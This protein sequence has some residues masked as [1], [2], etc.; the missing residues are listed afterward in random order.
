[1]L[2]VAPN[3]ASLKVNGK[4]WK[5]VKGRVVLSLVWFKETIPC[6]KIYKDVAQDDDYRH[7]SYNDDGH[8]DDDGWCS[9]QPSLLFPRTNSF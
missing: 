7:H 4:L 9:E 5:S 8:D 1:M 6:K 2:K 3:I